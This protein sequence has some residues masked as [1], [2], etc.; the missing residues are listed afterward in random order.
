MSDKLIYTAKNWG[1][2]AVVDEHNG[3][4]IYQAFVVNGQS[5]IHKHEHDINIIVS[6]DATIRILFFDDGPTEV[7]SSCLLVPGFK[8]TIK[9]GVIHQFVVV[10]P[11]AIIEI[12]YPG[13][14]DFDI[15]RF[16]V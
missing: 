9:P 4:L 10:E 12:Y 14:H 13:K 5:S 2:T 16:N 11:G 6:V 1:R 3:V 7:S 15:V 8:I